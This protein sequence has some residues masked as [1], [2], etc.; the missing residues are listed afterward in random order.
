MS[1]EARVFLRTGAYALV[2]AA[3]YWFLS[4]EVAGTVLLVVL[5][6]AAAGLTAML[7]GKGKVRPA[8]LPRDLATFGEDEP[9]I[10]LEEVPIPTLSLMPLFVAL[11]AAGVTVG[12]VFGA[13]LWLPGAMT[14]LGAT[15]RWATELD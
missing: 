11:G 2:V 3:V 14:M 6:L 12:L 10:E 8:R 4:Y 15:W 5:G 1:E 13:W 9:S 7:P